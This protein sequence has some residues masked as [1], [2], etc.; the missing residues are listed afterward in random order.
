M[1]KRHILIADDDAS[2][3][4]LLRSLLE[5][6]GYRVSEARTGGE[7]IS[8]LSDGKPV[9]LLL[10]DLRMPELSG[11]DILQRITDQG[12][13]VPVILMTA[14]GTANIA[15]KAIQLGAH[16][17]ITKPF[18]IDDLVVAVEKALDE[19]TLRREVARLRK[20]VARPYQFDNIIG[21]SPAM[22]DVFALIR[23][24]S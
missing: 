7:V 20:E 5:G 13:G 21:R 9:D 10:M 16:D 22:Q 23:R 18:E 14:F 8:L 11:M 24:L 2:I 17:Y 1:T 6:D 4:A 3:R 15:I 19:R 12:L